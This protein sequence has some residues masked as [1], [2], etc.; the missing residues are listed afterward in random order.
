MEEVAANTLRELVNFVKNAGPEVW[1]AYYRQVYL[2]ALSWVVAALTSLA[3]IP[4]LRR[5]I[6]YGRKQ[7]QNYLSDWPLAI[8][9][10]WVG[11]V[12]GAVFFIG[13]AWTALLRVFNPT[14]YA[15]QAM[16]H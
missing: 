14:Y 11:I 4:L 3:I 9:A 15:I 16:L 5:V 6:S 10:C 7:E 1:A 13:F 12:L 8:G 2:S